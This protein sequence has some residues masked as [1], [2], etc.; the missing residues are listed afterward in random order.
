MSRFR[1]QV[2]NREALKAEQALLPFARYISRLLTSSGVIREISFQERPP[3]GDWVVFQG[4]EGRGFCVRLEDEYTSLSPLQRSLSFVRRAHAVVKG[5]GG[6]RSF[7]FVLSLRA[8][9]PE[10]W[11]VCKVSGVVSTVWCGSSIPVLDP[12]ARTIGEERDPKVRLRLIGH[13]SSIGEG[14]VGTRVAMN[15]V[16]LSLPE[17]GIVG[18]G[19][20]NG[21]AM[22]MEIEERSDA[23]EQNVPGVRLDLGEIEVRL[24]DLVALRPGAVLDLGGS[25]LERCYMRLGSTILAEGRFATCDGKLTLTIES[26]V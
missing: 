8:D 13:L 18:R 23:G 16:A 2:H 26:V 6:P 15:N 19:Y 20:F 3:V 22:T 12:P 4:A 14:S 10:T 17:V 11:R 1:F 25:Q 21:G 9:A 7:P 5:F 24:S